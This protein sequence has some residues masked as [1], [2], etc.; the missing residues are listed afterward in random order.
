MYRW[1]RKRKRRQEVGREEGIKEGKKLIEASLLLE[2]LTTSTISKATGL[3][4]EEILE[5]KND[6]ETLKAL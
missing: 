3:K 5:I 4:E 2:G 1:K 6:Q